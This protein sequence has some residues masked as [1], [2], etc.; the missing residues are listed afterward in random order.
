MSYLAP[1]ERKI[2]L[3]IV[4][5]YLI[6]VWHPPESTLHPFVH[7]HASRACARLHALGHSRAV[8]VHLH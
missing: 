8:H 6:S 1:F 3:K 2:G 5:A 7:V 4:N